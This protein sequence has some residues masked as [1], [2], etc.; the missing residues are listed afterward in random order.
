MGRA[1]YGRS[2]ARIGRSLAGADPAR[3]RDGGRGA[4]RSARA[5]ARAS[6][7]GAEEITRRLAGSR[8]ARSVAGGE[9]DGGS[10]ATRRAESAAP[11]RALRRAA[12]AAVGGRDRAE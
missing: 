12:D 4:G 2:G 8:P 1:V 3:A 6:P 7:L 5:A 11:P 9:H 10:V